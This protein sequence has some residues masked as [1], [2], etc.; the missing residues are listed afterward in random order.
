ML[1]PH[2]LADFY[3]ENMKINTN[4]LH[5]AYTHNVTKVVSLLSTCVYPDKASYP[6][7]EEQIHNGSPHKSNYAYAYAKRMLDIQSQAYHDQYGCNFV[8]AVP[9]NL[10]GE[11]DNFHLKDS[12]VIPAMIRKMYEA[13]ETQTDVVLWGDGSPLREFTY[14]PDLAQILLFVLENYDKK[15]TH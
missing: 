13:K 5:G 6:L 4:I 7:T 1:I 11:H 9:N 2:T 10:Y 15:R 8:T 3:T 14:S 12:H